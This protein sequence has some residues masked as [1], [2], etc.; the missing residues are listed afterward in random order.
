MTATTAAPHAKIDLAAAIDASAALPRSL[1]LE[2]DALPLRFSE[3]TLAVALPS[4]DDELIAKLEAEARF[5]I[6]RELVMERRAIRDLLKDVYPRD[7]ES[8]MREDSTLSLLNEIVA[9]AVRIHAQD[10]HIEPHGESGGGRVRYDIDGLLQTRRTFSG[11]TLHRLIGLIKNVGRVEPND[12][13]RAGDGRLS[14]SADGKPVELRVATVPVQDGNERVCLRVLAAYG[15]IP[16]LQRLG[17]SARQAEVF[18]SEVRRPGGFIAIGGPTGSGKTTTAYSAISHL[19]LRTINGFS[20]ENPIECNIPHLSQINIKSFDEEA[21]AGMHFDDAIRAVLRHNPT[22]IFI[23]EARDKHTVKYAMTAS[24]SGIT[25]LTT[26]H[27]RDAIRVLRR[28]V[29]LDAARSTLANQ[30]T[31]MISQRLF[32]RLCAACRSEARPNEEGR[33]IAAEFGGELGRAWKAS[34]GGC[35]MCKRQGYAGRVAAFEMIVVDAEIARAIDEDRWTTDLLQIARAS[36]ILPFRPMIVQAL[37]HVDAGITTEDEV[38]R[39]L[40]YRDVDWISL[41]GV[42]GK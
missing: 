27:A 25:L 40:S 33:R 41:R 6:V 15:F 38:L 2:F 1:A 18:L 17:M 26:V 19:D 14:L 22:F 28:F 13:N 23:G 34:P 5:T 11:E 9:D 10:I 24:T 39:V 12:I 42:K 32:R 36:P 35:E 20:I 21:G 7:P 4:A 16:T 8:G 3:G 29:E 37:E 30:L 31:M